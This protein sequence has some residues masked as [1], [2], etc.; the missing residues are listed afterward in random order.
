MD[1]TDPLETVVENYSQIPMDFNS[2]SDIQA[3]LY[4]VIRQWLENRNELFTSITKGFDLK[5]DGSQPTYAGQYHSKL[6]TSVQQNQLS[7]VRT[8]VPIFHPLS[9]MISS[10]ER[11]NTVDKEEILDL[12]VIRKPFDRPIHM[13]NGKHRVSCE[14]VGAAVEIKHPRRQTVMPTH[15]RGS[16]DTL[17]HDELV[18]TIALD[19]IGI[20]S[21]LDELEDIG[22][23]YQTA[24]YFV[25]TSQYDIL[26]RGS[27]TKKQHLELAD[28]AV[29]K[30]R[31]MC[32]VTSVLY[33]YPNGWEWIVR[34]YK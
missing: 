1:I 13:S 11:P 32:E 28:A 10:N 4:E 21:D 5:L 12:A 29:D 6:K 27:S 17:S 14:K 18:D 31:D 30:I 16:V 3:R 9:M 34:N 7:R 24:V 20:R 19:R 33:G 23:N 8:E 26:R 2:E 15:T 22:E 25:L